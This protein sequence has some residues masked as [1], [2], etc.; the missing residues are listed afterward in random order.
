MTKGWKEPI[1]PLQVGRQVPIRPLKVKEPV[2]SGAVRPLNLHVKQRTAG[3]AKAT[4]ALETLP[5]ACVHDAIRRKREALEKELAAISTLEMV[6][7]QA[8][9]LQA[10][11][12]TLAARSR[13]DRMQVK[14]ELGS[15]RLRTAG[16]GEL[17]MVYIFKCNFSTQADCDKFRLFGA[18]E[19]H[20]PEMRRH[21]AA[22]TPLLL[23]NNDTHVLTGPF[24][25]D[26]EPALDIVEGAFNSRFRAQVRV[27]KMEGRPLRQVGVRGWVP[28]GSQTR[29]AGRRVLQLLERGT[30]LGESSQL[31]WNAL[32]QDEAYV[33]HC[34]ERTY[35]ECRTLRLFGAPDRMLDEMRKCIAANSPLLLYNTSTR[36]LIG[37][38]VCDGPPA[39]SIVPGAFGGIF[40]AQVAVARLETKRLRQIQLPKGPPFGHTLKPDAVHL[41]QQLEHGREIPLRDQEWWSGTAVVPEHRRNANRATAVTMA[42]EE[43]SSYRQEPHDILLQ[44]ALEDAPAAAVQ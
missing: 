25:R 1:R 28:S 2:R 44:L 15:S 20:L 8:C 39:M 11:I 37:P 24:V 41:L 38:L 17:V 4:R 29:G 19:S 43:R 3:E 22:G 30:D 16:L 14:E 35:N 7:K 18:P 10:R 9:A 33:F 21:I 40:N 31:W 26:G 34:N 13:R 27:V 36:Q 5:P 6:S 32:V 23:F 12:Q 42:R